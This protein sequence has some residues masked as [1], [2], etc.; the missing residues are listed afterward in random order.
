MVIAAIIGL[1]V[2]IAIV[3]IARGKSSS[4]SMDPE[5]RPL[6]L[7]FW[8]F[9]F[10]PTFLGPYERGGHTDAMFLNIGNWEKLF[11]TTFK[12]EHK[13]EWN[14]LHVAK[15]SLNGKEYIVYTFPEPKQ[16]PEAKY[17]MVVLDPAK[18]N[19]SYYTMECS[20]GGDWVLG[21]YASGGTRFNLGSLGKNATIKE[22]TNRIVQMEER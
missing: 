13:I 18:Q 22:F 3:L 15:S 1:I 7:Y 6:G 10:I 12:D 14:K 2:I 11:K 8:E 17:G 21:S 4:P 16:I 5:A 20:F 9:T 19:A